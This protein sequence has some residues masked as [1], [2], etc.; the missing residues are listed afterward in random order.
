MLALV[1]GVLHTLLVGITPE[2]N[3]G[4]DVDPRFYTNRQVLL[5]LHTNII[6]SNRSPASVIEKVLGLRYD[7]DL[8]IEN[9]DNIRNEYSSN[10]H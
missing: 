4:G 6:M 5:V 8:S 1:P 7:Q 9:L 3:R 2:R 10:I